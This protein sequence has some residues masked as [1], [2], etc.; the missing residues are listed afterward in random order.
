MAGGLLARGFD[1]WFGRALPGAW[2]AGAP[3]RF[4][5]RA[6]TAG[7][8]RKISRTRSWLRRLLG[9]PTLIA[10]TT[11]PALPRT[12]AP[13]ATKPASSSSLAS[14]QPRARTRASSRRRAAGSTTVRGVAACSGVSSSESRAASGRWA[15][16]TFPVEVA[17]AGQRVPSEGIEAT[18]WSPAASSRISTSRP[19]STSSVAVSRVV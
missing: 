10:A 17:C 4:E 18:T 8:E 3:R 11:S 6:V 16:S 9:P 1:D 5:M 2:F 13:T 15:S 12:G 7:S 14:A 19:T